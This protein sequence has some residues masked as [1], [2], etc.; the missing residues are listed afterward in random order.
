MSNFFLILSFSES[1]KNR[2]RGQILKTV[3]VYFPSCSNPFDNVPLVEKI[4]PS[5]H[6]DTVSC[7]ISRERRGFSKDAATICH[8]CL[9][10]PQ[11][12]KNERRKGGEIFFKNPKLSIVKGLW[13]NTA[14]SSLFHNNSLINFFSFF[15]KSSFENFVP[16]CIADP[17]YCSHWSGY[18]KSRLCLSQ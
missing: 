4:W 2:V 16:G 10:W 3:V 7:Y 18:Q 17:D 8:H 1:N 5:L 15:F 13:K 6:E 12:E 9:H 11:T 14:H